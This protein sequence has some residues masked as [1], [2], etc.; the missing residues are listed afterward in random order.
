[1]YFQYHRQL[2]EN[3]AINTMNIEW[4]LQ[5]MKESEKK[6]LGMLRFVWIL[7][8]TSKITHI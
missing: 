3:I 1:M 7:C 8:V 5:K 4:K 6:K 2:R